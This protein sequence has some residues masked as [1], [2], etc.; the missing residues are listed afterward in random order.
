MHTLNGNLPIILYYVVADTAYGMYIVTDD[1]PVHY[2]VLLFLDKQTQRDQK[3]FIRVY[4]RV[5]YIE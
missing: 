2:F 5:C 1:L 4:D 3:V